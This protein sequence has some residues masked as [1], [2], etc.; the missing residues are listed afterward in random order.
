MA[1][2]FHL[3]T[4]NF[5]G[6]KGPA[7]IDSNNG[8]TP[9]LAR[10]SMA[11]SLAL[12]AGTT[13]VEL[14][15]GTGV[16]KE[17]IDVN[18]TATNV[19]KTVRAHGK[20]KLRATGS[21]LFRI[22]AGFWSIIGFQFEDFVQIGQTYTLSTTTG[23]T[24]TD[25]IFKN[26]VFNSTKTLSFVNCQ[27]EACSNI[28]AIS[29]MTGCKL[30]ANSNFGGNSAGIS[31]FDSCDVEDGSKVI[32]ATGATALT[33]DYNNIRGAATIKKA[34]DANYT[35]IATFKAANPTICAN[36]FAAD[37]LYKN[38]SNSIYKVSTA[39]PN[40][41]TGRS[42][43]NIGDVRIAYAVAAGATG[44][45]NPFSPTNPNVTLYRMTAVGESVTV[46]RA[47]GYVEG[48]R[49]SDWF[50]VNGGANVRLGPYEP[51]QNLEFNK[52]IA[53]PDIENMNVSD[54]TIGAGAS[55]GS[56]NPD[57]LTYLLQ[58][59]SQ[60]EKPD[61]DLT[62]ANATANNSGRWPAGTW[63]P[64]TYFA[65]PVV[66]TLGGVIT[67]TGQVTFPWADTANQ[68][69]ITCRWVRVW[70]YFRDNYSN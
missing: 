33:C 27:F 25:C 66:H 49:I 22:S 67:T 3:S 63:K 14:A 23:I 57:K 30:L 35:D 37:P 21:N 2:W 43:V 42:G 26:C 52:S 40:L 61:Q 60:I 28:S 54:S 4:A 58:T 8:T 59:S 41:R 70:E 56:N 19:L 13:A 46:D 47:A 51:D 29:S 38:P 44:A 53:G 7:S 15:I 48:Y 9:E 18:G 17:N 39:S 24:F 36:S 50:Q 1:N 64:F 20:V 6:S 68:A 45:L 65:D 5:F 16:Y 69:F 31:T 55:D 10:A 62:S 11:G 34:G 12:V 32:I